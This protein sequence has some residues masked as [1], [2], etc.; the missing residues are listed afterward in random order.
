M[1]LGNA[2]DE[3][4]GAVGVEAQTAVAA[5]LPAVLLFCDF[6]DAWNSKQWLFS[7]LISAP[8]D[9]ENLSRSLWEDFTTKPKK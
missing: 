3:P 8:S 2:A 1:L 7:C 6:A 5:E 9:S 4:E